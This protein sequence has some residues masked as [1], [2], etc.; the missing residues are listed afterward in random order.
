MATLYDHNGNLIL[1]K[2]GKMSKRMLDRL[3]ANLIMDKF[4]QEPVFEK[5]ISRILGP[6][7]KPFKKKGTTKTIKF[8]RYNSD[9]KSD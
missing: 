5:F 7:G 9:S 1:N 2:W 8:R 4:S 6:D 3:S